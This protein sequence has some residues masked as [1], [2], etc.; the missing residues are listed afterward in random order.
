LSAEWIVERPTVNDKVA[1]L[2]NFGEVTFTDSYTKIGNNV[3]RIGD[4]SYSK[5]EMT[6][7]VSKL[8]ASVSPINP[9][10]SSFTVKYLA[11]L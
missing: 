1:L 3:G 8:L 6:N 5:I 11:S 9:D 4:F 7:D 10:A 2:T